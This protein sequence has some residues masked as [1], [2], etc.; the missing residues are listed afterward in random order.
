MQSNESLL[1]W[2]QKFLETRCIGCKFQL[3][4]ENGY[5]VIF[6]EGCGHEILRCPDNSEFLLNL[7]T[8]EFDVEKFILPEIFWS[9]GGL[10]SIVI[11]A[12]KGKNSYVGMDGSSYVLSGDVI[13]FCIR[14]L[15]RLEE[16]DE[17][18]D[19]DNHGRF[20]AKSSHAARHNYLEQPVVDQF[21][22]FLKKLLN[23]TGFH[24]FQFHKKVSLRL[25][26]D[27]DNPY[28]YETSNLVRTLISNFKNYPSIGTFASIFFGI[29]KSLLLRFNKGRD[30]YLDDPYNTFPWL[31][32]YYK[33]MQLTAIFFLM[34][35][36]NA[37]PADSSYKL[38]APRIR[39]LVSGILKHG[40]QIGVHYSYACMEEPGKL[41]Q[42]INEFIDY[43]RQFSLSDSAN[44]EI[45]GHFLRWKPWLLKEISHGRQSLKEHTFGY[46][47][48]IGFRS[49]TSIPYEIN[50]P[51]IT[52]GS[53]TIVPLSLMDCS[54][55]DERYMN[56]GTGSKAVSKIIELIDS[57]RKVNGEISVLWHNERLNLPAERKLFT[58]IIDLVSD[59]V[60]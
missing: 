2:F 14:C 50:V 23:H 7:G 42:N 16:F 34:G 52:N 49:G 10:K 43:R 40:H 47:E 21:I 1:I 33:K 22:I 60:A 27:V 58:T 48:R 37:H 12:F 55:I 53:I 59:D 57:I 36:S 56:M 15:L 25:S 18:I 24:N 45:R 54:L 30:A 26:H 46:A 8:I 3:Y 51:G 38:K 11:P 13:S 28:F 6:E 19:T 35:Y 39:K 44:I 17:D 32:N 5:W 20:Q 29:L 41:M 9:E 4:S 31:L